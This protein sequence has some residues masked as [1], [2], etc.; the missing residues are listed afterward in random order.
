MFSQ[1]SETNEEC[2]SHI[3]TLIPFEPSMW[4][5]GPGILLK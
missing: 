4:K 3:E 2:H 1:T 5:F